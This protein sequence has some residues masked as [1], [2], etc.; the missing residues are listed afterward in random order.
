MLGHEHTKARGLLDLETARS[1]GARGLG[2]LTA[3]TSTP[4]PWSRTSPSAC[5]SGSRSS[6]PSSRDASVL[7]LDEPTA[8]LTPQETDELLGIMRELRRSGHLHRLHH[9]QTARGAGRRRPDHGD[10]P[11]QGRRRG[12]AWATQAELAGMMVGREVSLTVDKPPA[13][14]G[15]PVA[16][17]LEDLCGSTIW[18]V[19]RSCGISTSTS[20]PARSSAIAGVQGN[21]QTELA[22]VLTGLFEGE[23]TGSITMEGQRT[24]GQSTQQI[25]DGGLG[26]V[27]EDREH[28]GLIVRSRRPRTSSST[29]WQ[30]RPTP[31]GCSC[32]AT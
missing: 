19:G 17:G 7:I 10:P 16:H 26:Y 28:D 3:S 8:V 22:Q 24:R 32:A 6:R 11:R 27:P 5:S 1:R 18:T 4:T 29:R 14:P 30:R 21:G 25:L 12:R 13:E 9:P 15:E 23:V 31:P 20:G 2:A